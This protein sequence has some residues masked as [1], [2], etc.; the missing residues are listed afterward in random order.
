MLDIAIRDSQGRNQNA[1]SNRKEHDT[2]HPD[3]KE[4][5]HRRC[6]YAENYC[7]DGEDNRCDERIEESPGN[8]GQR[9]DKSWEEDLADK[10]GV[11][12]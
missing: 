8:D 12:D 10:L 1:S 4:H 2:K 6:F 3:G 9:K 7:D 11:S 5:Q